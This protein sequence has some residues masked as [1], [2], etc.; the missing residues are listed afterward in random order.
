MITLNECLRDDTNIMLV[1]PEKEKKIFSFLKSKDG[2]IYRKGFNHAEFV[3]E[4]LC[5]IRNLRC[6]HYFL[7]H[8]GD[9]E[10]NSVSKFGDLDVSWNHI[11]VASYDFKRPSKS[12]FDL[13]TLGISRVG[14]PDWL[15]KLLSMA[16]NR[17]NRR[18]LLNELEELIAL[19]TFMGQTDRTGTNIMIERNR[20]TRE[21]HLAPIY[22]FQC[23]LYTGYADPKVIYNNNLHPLATVEDYQQLIAEYPE[24]SEKLKSYLDVDLIDSIRKSYRLNGLEVPDESLSSYVDF[25]EQ[26]K[27][28]IRTITRTK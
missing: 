17:K 10:T 5:G 6:S 13:N 2:K 27:Q 3:G 12:Y 20:L 1:R 9:Y 25:Q 11:G 21:L 23:S 22:D 19:D 7:V 26:K 4:Y 28:L 8:E 15:S 18:E 14:Y 24:L 16:P